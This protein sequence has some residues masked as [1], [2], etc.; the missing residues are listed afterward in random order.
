MTRSIGLDRQRSA[1][2]QKRAIGS[3]RDVRASK[4]QSQ[5]RVMKMQ[6]LHGGE[7][8]G[9]NSGVRSRCM[10]M[11]M[12]GLHDGASTGFGNRGVLPSLVEQNMYIRVIAPT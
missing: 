7:G 11:K 9:A 1:L 10:M 3:T 12:Q 8:E 4:A 2:T 6:G 5:C